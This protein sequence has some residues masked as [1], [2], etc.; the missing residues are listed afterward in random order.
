MTDAKDDAA[1]GEVVEFG[2]EDEAPA[3]PLSGRRLKAKKEAQK[4]KKPGTFESMGLSPWLLRA[5]KR[6]GFRLPTPIQ[7]RTLPLILQGLDVVAMARTGSGKTAAFVIPMLQKLAG[8][9][10]RAGARALVLSPTRELALQTHKVVRELSKGS[11]LRTAALVGGDAMEAQF[12]E[13]AANPDILVATPGRLLHHLEEVEGMGLGSI[14]YVVFDEADR[15]F[16]MGFADQVREILSK[17]RDGRQAL[18]FS[19]TLPRSLADFASAGLAQPQLVRLDVERRLSPDLGLAFFTVRPDDKL[20]AL[21]WLLREMLP[22]DQSTVVFVSTRHHA[23]FLHNLLAREGLETAVVY[24]AMDQTARK[25]HVAKFRAKRVG[26]LITTDVAARGID[27]PLID[28]VVNYDFPPKPELAGRAARMGRPGTALSLVLREELPYLLDL[29]LYLGRAIEAAPEAPD[30]A[31][32]EAARADGG[33]DAAEGKSVFGSF[34]AAILEPLQDH[35]RAAV[36]AA[37]DLASVQRTLQNAYSLY[38]KTRPAASSE[39]VKRAKGLPK[40][41]PHPMLL[42]KLPATRRGN[43]QNEAALA[44]F[45][46]K[47][48]N[49]RPTAT[50]LEAE[51]A[52]VRPST[53]GQTMQTELEAALRFKSNDVMRQKRATHA[54]VIEKER[55]KRQAALGLFEGVAGAGAG[56]KGQREGKGA[57]RRRPDEDE[58]DEEEDG[59]SSGEEEAGSGSGSE[60]E[61]GGGYSGGD[62]S[63]EDEEEEEEQGEGRS[64]KG[65][66]QLRD[67]TAGSNRKRG[68]GG[69]GGEDGGSLRRAAAKAMAVGDA[70]LNEGKYRDSGFFLGHNRTDNAGAAGG[71]TLGL[72]DAAEELRSA[73]LDLTG[74]DQEAM[75]QQQRQYQWDKRK[76]RY[77]QRTAGASSGAGERR[78]AAVGGRNEAGSFITNGGGKKGEERKGQL[79]KKWARQNKTRVA[80]SGGFEDDGRVAAELANRF[81]PANRHKS[82]RAALGV[83]GG[84]VAKGGAAKRGGELRP[85]AQVAKERKRKEDL[86]QRMKERQK[87]NAAR[88]KRSEKK[89]SKGGG[90]RGGGGGGGSSYG[91]GGRGRGSSGG[92]RGG[93]GGGRGRGGGGGGRGRGGRR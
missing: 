93:G 36:D 30:A 68:G 4:K 88:A 14:E 90:G 76:R 10:P 9:S 7:R 6:K 11:D 58:E 75:T 40:E 51:I 21:V 49:F 84:G 39:S 31:A 38:L 83:A 32:V 57:K 56:G 61:D 60:G 41:G 28:N 22:P 66:Q 81:K 70:V 27:I 62:S 64:K 13:L 48:K 37:G 25:I 69:G 5:I 89:G 35:L 20:A 55:G 45:T 47:L 78:S 86:Q 19:A 12:A 43:L 82:W 87:A 79:Y 8:H 16:E 71:E 85:Q 23:D 24:G 2:W 1:N 53:G 34:P 63:S 42:G 77:V 67:A 15:L 46:Q 65:K 44:E 52:K 92:G 74:E 72:D 50:V 29:H 18:L 17:L 26:V 91:G 73:V 80:A 54:A 3:K 33:A 59:S